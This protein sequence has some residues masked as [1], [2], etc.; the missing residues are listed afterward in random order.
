MLETTIAGSLPRPD[1]LAEPEALKG[2]WKLSGAELEEG[3]RRAAA[4]WIRHQEDA[5]I[6]ILTDG[7]QF[8]THFVHSFLEHIT[9]ALKRGD[10]ASLVGFGTFTVVRRRPRK[11]RN[12]QTGE[13][14]GIPARRVARFTPGRALK[15]TLR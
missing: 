6:D 8:R 1:W 10:R 11:G 14:I 3:K 13:T 4:E 7:E 5:G 9:R 15:G 2:A 12:P